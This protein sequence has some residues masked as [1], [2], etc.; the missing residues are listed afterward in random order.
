[1]EIGGIAKSL[2]KLPIKALY[3]E[4]WFSF[5][6]PED[7]DPDAIIFN[8]VEKVEW[9][10]MKVAAS[11]AACIEVEEMRFCDCLAKSGHELLIEVISQGFGDGEILLKDRI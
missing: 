4:G 8:I 10:A 6:V 9:E 11:Q 2:R 5:I 1:M 7:P 3:S